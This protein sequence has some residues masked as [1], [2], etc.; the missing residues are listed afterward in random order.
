[1]ATSLRDQAITDAFGQARASHT[2]TVGTVE[3]SKPY[4]SPADR[5]DQWIYFLMVDRFNNPA[6]QPE[7]LPFDAKFGGFQGGTLGGVRERL[8]YI[9]SLGAGAIWMTPVFQNPVWQDAAYHGYGFQNLLKIDARFGTEQDLQD[10]VDEAH[11]RGMYVILDIVINHAGDVF[12][13]QGFGAEAPFQGF[14]YSIRW[15]RADGSAKQQWQVA[16]DD[17]Q[18]DAELTEGA[19]VFPDELR[20]NRLFRRQGTAFGEVGDFFSLKEIATDFGQMTADRGFE[21]TARNALITAYQYVIAKFDIDGYRIDTLKH[22]ERPFARIF[23]NAMREFALSIGKKNFFTFGEV[24]DNEEKLAQYTG[25]FANDPDDLVGVDAA[26]DF[27]LF[28]TLPNVLK[29]FQAPSALAGLFQ[30]RRDVQ[31]GAT[32]QGVLISSH[33]EAGQF[34]TTFLDNHDQTARFRFVDPANPPR[35]D[36]QVSMAVACLYSLL[37]IPVLYYGTEQG[38]H[39]SG[40]SDQNVREALWAK[41][42]AFATNNPFFIEVQKIAR[43]RAEQPALRYGRQYFRPISGSGADFGISGS[44]PGIVSFSRVLNDTEVLVLANTFTASSFTGFALVDFA[45]NPDAAQFTRLYSNKASTAT[46]P[47]PSITK[48]Q[49]TVTVHNP[50]GGTSNGPIRAVPFTLQPNG[51]PDP[52]AAA[53]ATGSTPSAQRRAIGRLPHHQR[54]RGCRRSSST[55]PGSVG[56]P[57][58]LMSELATRAAHRR[59]R[60]R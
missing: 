52:R 2:R 8:G 15:R 16:P 23:G 44:A 14:P 27:P 40:D 35:F 9:Q 19:A 42:D 50:A 3:I 6:G 34:F 45:L 33:G 1:M 54:R 55:A 5:R 51:D 17:L 58:S 32:G 30:H 41:P 4:P 20:D 13:Y 11:A 24:F 56:P 46:N 43:L 28:F 12:E 25:R 37:G 38:L 36:D 57:S 21:F 39:G 10:L 7:H 48:A 47:G 60:P 31:T 59:Q 18:G 22:V 49:G 26:L 29:G 53:I